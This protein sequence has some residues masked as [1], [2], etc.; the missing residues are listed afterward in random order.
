MDRDDDR[1][2]SAATDA[3]PAGRPGDRDKYPREKIVTMNVVTSLP[4]RERATPP[5]G[6]RATATF[7]AMSAAMTECTGSAGYAVHPMH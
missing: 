5:G 4:D 6:G 7:A 2:R 3:R 1:R